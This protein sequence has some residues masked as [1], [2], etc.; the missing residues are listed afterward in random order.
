M[1]GMLCFRFPVQGLAAASLLA[2][3]TLPRPFSPTVALRHAP[4]LGKHALF[5]LAFFTGLAFAFAASPVALSP[6]DTPQWVVE[7]SDPSTKKSATGFL[8]GLRVGGTIREAARLPG[9]GTRFLLANVRPT[10][11]DAPPLP[12][13]LALSWRNPPPELAS[14]GPGQRLAATLPIR[15]VHGFANPGVWETES[16]WRD[17]NVY[18]RSWSRNDG[19]KNGKTAPYGLTG[20]ASAA[21]RT[22]E[23]LRTKTLG[24]LASGFNDKGAPQVSQ[25]AAFIPALLFGDRSF[26]D[27]AKL[28]LVAKSTLAH[29]LALSGMHL[30]YAAAAGYAAAH[31]LSFLF[32]TLF[33]RVPRQK[34]GLVLAAPVCLVYLWLGGAPPSLVRAAIMLLFWA[35]LLWLKKPKVLADGLILA[36]A[37]ILV[38]SPTAM[39]DIRLQLSAISVAG[40]ALAAPL[41]DRLIRAANTPR[42]RNSLNSPAPSRIRAR[43]VFLLLAAAGGTSIAAQASVLPL[44]LN[45][46][47][48]TGLWFPL[49]LV[50]L[51]VL[52]AWVMP[53]AFAG[54]FATACGQPWAASLLYSLASAPCEGLLEL[55]QWMDATGFLAAP[56]ALRPAWPAS[57]GYW[58]LML[59]IPAAWSPGAASPRVFAALCVG[60]VLVSAPTIQ[61]ML[62]AKNETVRLQL[63]DVG[64]GQA[65][66]T[67]WEGKNGCGR[68][69]V[70]GGGFVSETFDVGRQVIAPALTRNTPPKLDWLINSHPDADHLQGL[71]FPL[72]TFQI[73]NTVF[74]QNFPGK[75]TK[76][77]ARRDEILTKR[78]ITPRTVSAGDILRLA[79]DLVFEVLHPQQNPAGLSSNDAALALRLVWRGRPLALIC[80]DLERKGIEQLL[81]RGAETTAEVLVLPHHGSA[82]SFSPKLYDAVRPKLALAACGYANQWN[83]PAGKIRQAL[84]E[85]SISLETTAERG[86]ITIE[87]R[88]NT[89]MQTKFARPDEQ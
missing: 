59:L 44:T 70:D 36:V 60:L 29:S 64:Q 61:T 71:L 28:E 18:F 5:A 46:F 17:R 2:L 87:W 63:I 7:A 73:A 67:S 19:S 35:V 82:G 86:Q 26:C 68:A 34:V 54:L 15:K 78:S 22:R 49:N 42:T 25:A 23:A 27:P 21:W 52:G 40:I 72:E 69:L 80:G 77:M 20:E 74:A 13:L 38:W 12:G 89:P 9:G 10:E 83:F 57:A 16:Y 85:R 56:A 32:P 33:L 75:T 62:P 3:L 11:Q 6:T 65:V 45:A 76:T 88:E 39:Y 24:A 66:L 43:R 30:G 81:S 41:L 58:L 4:S 55:L 50:W 31:L 8:Q 14:A 84:A 53:C 79:P 48:G 51:P 1:A 47:P 37:C